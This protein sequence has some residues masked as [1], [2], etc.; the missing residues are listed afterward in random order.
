MLY[1]S[2]IF[3]LFPYALFFHFFTAQLQPIV[4]LEVAVHPLLHALPYHAPYCLLRPRLV[5]RITIVCNAQ[6]TP[7][8]S[9]TTAPSRNAKLVSRTPH[10]PKPQPGSKLLR[11]IESYNPFETALPTPNMLHRDLPHPA[12]SVRGEDEAELHYL[13]NIIESKSSHQSQH[14]QL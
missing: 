12:P 4:M 3:L 7:R 1:P 5:T 13:I 9:S 14:K 6:P 8:M 10:A 11:Y 2:T